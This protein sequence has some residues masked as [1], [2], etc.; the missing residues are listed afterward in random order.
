MPRGPRDD[1]P[2]TAHHVMVRGIERRSIF[3]DDRD[4]A[5]FVRRLTCLL[6][7]LGFLC[8]VWA[9][10]PN[11]VHSFAPAPLAFRS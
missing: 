1:S 8:F 11:H 9:L 2:G 3:V 5:E 10:M 7:E 4:R 6:P